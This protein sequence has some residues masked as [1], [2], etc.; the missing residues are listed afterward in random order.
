[1]TDPTQQLR[2]LVALVRDYGVTPCKAD[3]DRAEQAVEWVSKEREL[4]AEQAVEWVS[5]ERELRAEIDQLRV[6]LREARKSVET[7]HAEVV[8]ARDGED[9]MRAELDAARDSEADQRRDYDRRDRR[10]QRMVEL[11]AKAKRMV[12]KLPSLPHAIARCRGEG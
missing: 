7:L 3:K 11:L 12:N 5:K 10:A 8:S 2:E 4:R 9:R 6:D 1:M